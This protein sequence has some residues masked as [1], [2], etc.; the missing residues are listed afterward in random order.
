MTVCRQAITL[1]TWLYLAS[2]G[3]SSRCA[4][5]R[6]M[7]CRSIPWTTSIEPRFNGSFNMLPLMVW[8]LHHGDKVRPNFLR[9][10][11][12]LGYSD[13]SMTFEDMYAEADERL[14]IQDLVIVQIMYSTECYQLP[15][16]TTAT[17]FENPQTHIP[18]TGAPH[19]LIDWNF[20]VRMLYIKKRQLLVQ[21]ILK[22]SW[23]SLLLL[24]KQLY[25]YF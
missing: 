1:L 2:P 17:Q 10:C 16:A 6:R 11:R 13:R 12:K 5:W 3:F 7:G 21:C 19:Y 14:F 15:P 4:Y 18:A 8:F 25:A 20:L 9:R 22:T 24:H 23:I